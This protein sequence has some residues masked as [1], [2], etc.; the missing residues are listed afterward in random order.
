MTVATARDEPSTGSS[1]LYNPVARKI[2]F[3]IVLAV[4]VAFLV[5]A[6]STNAIERLR[7]QNTSSGFEF[8]GRIAGFDISQSPIEFSAK[9]S[10][11]GRA[12]IVGILNTLIVAAIGIPAATIIGFLIGIARLSSNWLVS[13]IA[14]VY[15]E[16]I[17]NIPLLLQLYFWYSAVLKPLPLPRQ[18]IT[19][20]DTVFLNNRGV[21][22][23]AVSFGGAGPAITVS[24]VLAAV[25][26]LIVNRWARA[27]QE[28]T[29]VRPPVW[30]IAL[31]L[32]VILPIVAFLGAGGSISVSVP[33]LKG[34]N[35][36]GGSQIIPEFGAL[37]LGLSLY[38][39]SFIAEIVRG[40]ILAVSHGQTEASRA[41]GL[42]GGQTL[43]LVVVP[44]AMRVIIP[45]LAN[46]YLNLVKNSSL[47]VAIGFPELVQ[48]FAGS[49]LNITNQAIECMAI[50]MGVYLVIS[51]L[52][53]AFMNWFN[54]RVALVER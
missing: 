12:L 38:T 6:A 50:T 24:L 16:F 44:Q 29:G 45:P 4:I 11:H 25:L 48:V 22:L 10:T 40:G 15:V 52:I 47:A 34:F 18:S 54:R 46:Q 41:I 37:L 21:Y 26:T 51:L 19:L 31:G 8:L 1:L 36:V 43:R 7:Q 14:T 49:V 3:Q 9:N 30:L 27:R 33:Q 20:F 5:Y 42:D 39:A 28:A 2:A 13:R 32:F 23:P 53:S 35:L 17:R